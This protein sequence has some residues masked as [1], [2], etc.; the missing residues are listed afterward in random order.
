MKVRVRQPHVSKYP[1][2]VSFKSGDRFALGRQDEEIPGWIW[3]TLDSGR[4]GWAPLQYIAAG[5]DHARGTAKCNYSAAELNTFSGEELTLG[6][7]LNGWYWV[8]NSQGAEGWVPADT[9]H[10]D[11]VSERQV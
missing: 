5:A 1:D 11:Q 7:G 8:R 4:A 10:L 6:H 3:I 9:L 2:P